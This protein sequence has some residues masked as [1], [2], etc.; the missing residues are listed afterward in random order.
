[1]LDRSR[2]DVQVSLT[3]MRSNIED[4]GITRDFCVKNNIGLGFQPMVMRTFG[5]GGM[6]ELAHVLENLAFYPEV[7]KSWE[8]EFA[9]LIGESGRVSGLGLDTCDAH[10]KHLILM[11]DGSTMLCFKKRH[12]GLS[13]ASLRDIWKSREYEAFRNV[14]DNGRGPCKVCAYRE[15][16]LGI[17]IND[18]IGYL[19]KDVAENLSKNALSALAFDSG[20][21]SRERIKTFLSDMWD[22]KNFVQIDKINEKYRGF[23]LQK[24][25]SIEALPELPNQN[26]LMDDFQDSMIERASLGEIIEDLNAAFYYKKFKGGVSGKSVRAVIWGTSGAYDDHWKAFVEQNP[27]GMNIVGLIDSD[28][29][30]W[31]KKLTGLEIYSPA[32]LAEIKPDLVIIA[33]VYVEE[34]KRQANT[35]IAD[36]RFE[37]VTGIS[38]KGFLK[39]SKMI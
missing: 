23:S 5:L 6:F 38:G 7:V 18:V 21:N 15:Q 36:H 22:K 34:I 25:A 2:V 8:T 32:S 3:L 13:R 1:M 37:I 28:E 30:K 39:R 20:L 14:V 9:D 4:F 11:A 29:T 27:L 35:I 10:R 12:I 19:G 26:D 33:S 31:G 24:A 17:R 16:C